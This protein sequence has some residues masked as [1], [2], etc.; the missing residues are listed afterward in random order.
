MWWPK[1]SNQ[2]IYQIWSGV[3]IPYQEVFYRT[4]VMRVK[5]YLKVQTQ[6]HCPLYHIYPKYSDTASIVDQGQTAPKDCSRCALFASAFRKHSDTTKG[7][8]QIWKWKSLLIHKNHSG[9]GIF[10]ESMCELTLKCYAKLQQT[11]VEVSFFFFFFWEN[12]ISCEL[13]A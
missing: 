11:N 2:E 8:V 6:F 10:R 5:I 12:N 13:S 3:L 4:I 7:L 1:F 9:V